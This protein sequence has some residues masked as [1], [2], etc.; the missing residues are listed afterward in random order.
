MNDLEH[1]KK[2]NLIF[3]RYEI[4]YL[5]TYDVYIKLLQ[6]INHLLI[7]DKTHLHSLHHPDN[8]Y[9]YM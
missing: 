1:E 5:L 7:P 3:E 2:N 4:K 9:F 8:I 6:K